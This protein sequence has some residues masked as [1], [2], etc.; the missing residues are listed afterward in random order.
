MHFKCIG[1]PVCLY[2]ELQ[3][4]E[5]KQMERENDK[6]WGIVLMN[7]NNLETSFE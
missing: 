3:I 1:P 2:D 7:R 4:I 6:K 5:K